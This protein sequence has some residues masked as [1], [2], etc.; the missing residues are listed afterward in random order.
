MCHVTCVVCRNPGIEASVGFA[1]NVPDVNEIYFTIILVTLIGCFSYGFSERELCCVAERQQLTGGQPSFRKPFTRRATGG[2]VTP[3]P[4]EFKKEDT[5][6]PQSKMDD[7][8]NMSKEAAETEHLKAKD[9]S[10]LPTLESMQQ[11]E[12][13]L[14]SS[15]PSL[16]QTSELPHGKKTRLGEKEKSAV[17]KRIS[18]LSMA[19]QQPQGDGFKSQACL[20]L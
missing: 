11:S 16:S 12:T 4:T 3:R 2:L 6:S 19:G 10:K 7:T 14:P 8:Q 18:T 9:E 5:T 13:E 20:I 15:P 1:S 17:T